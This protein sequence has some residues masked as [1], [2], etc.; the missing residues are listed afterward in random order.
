[1]SRSLSALESKL[2]L[3]MEW[4]KKK[5]IDVKST[6]RILGISA[7]YARVVL[8]RLDSD[9]WLKQIVPGQY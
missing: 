2:I 1:M 6:A 8:H 9:N 5:V 4:E 7:D 3:R